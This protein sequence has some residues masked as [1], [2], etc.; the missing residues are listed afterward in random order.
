MWNDFWNWICQAWD[1]IRAFFVWYFEETPLFE[2]TLDNF[3]E[4]T[5]YIFQHIKP[6][7]GEYIEYILGY[8]N[9]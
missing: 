6:L 5:V 3:Y 7:I 8:I 4:I 2:D 1:A 9:S